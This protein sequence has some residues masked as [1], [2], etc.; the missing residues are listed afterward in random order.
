V[1]SRAEE[2]RAQEPLDDDGPP[3]NDVDARAELARSIEPSVYPAR[4]GELLASAER[5][6]AP[7]WVTDALRRLPDDLYETTEAVWE[8]MARA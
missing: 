6:H 3:G 5:E 7:E 4:P 2:F 8:A 1:E